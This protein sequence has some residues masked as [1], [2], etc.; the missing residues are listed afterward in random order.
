MPSGK[1]HYCRLLL[2]DFASVRF[3]LLVA[4]FATVRFIPCRLSFFNLAI[5]LHF[6]AL[7]LDQHRHLLHLFLDFHA[8]FGHHHHLLMMLLLLNQN[9]VVQSLCLRNYVLA[10]PLD[11]FRKFNFLLRAYFQI[12]QSPENFQLR[13]FHLFILNPS[14]FHFPVTDHFFTPLLPQ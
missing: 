2:T 6:F 13:S 9:S 3:G 1:G 10:Q 5:L 12:M 8:H 11:P 4:H 7:R 14:R